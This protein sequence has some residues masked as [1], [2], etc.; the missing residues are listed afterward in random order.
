MRVQVKDKNANVVAIIGGGFSGTMVAYHLLRQSDKPLQITIFEPRTTLGLGLAY[1]TPCPDHLLNVPAAG[2]SAFVDQPLHFFHHAQTLD[3]RNT[4][5]TF[6]SRRQF[7]QYIN[8]LFEAAL[9]EQVGHSFEHRTQSVVDI[10]RRDGRYALRLADGVAYDTD[11]V[12]LATGNLS[13]RPFRWA[14]AFADDARY[15]HD[16]WQSGAIEAID[17]NSDVLLLGTGLTAVDKLIELHNQQHRGRIWATSRH[18]LLPFAH[19]ERWVGIKDERDWDDL[20]GPLGTLRGAVRQLRGRALANMVQDK[21]AWRPVFDGC[22]A[23]TQIWW[24]GLELLEQKRFMRHLRTYYDVHR[25]RM[26]P[27]IDHVVQEMRRDGRL[28][29]IA[30]RVMGAHDNGGKIAVQLQPRHGGD[31]I[32]LQL[33]CIINCTGPQGNVEAVEQPLFRNLI[34]GGRASQNAMGSSLLVQANGCVGPVDD[35]FY[36]IGPLLQ[37]QLLE[38]VAVPEL[39]VQATNVAQAILRRFD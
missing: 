3:D 25:H 29:I 18:G 15:L 26:A 16:P 20:D 10:E 27:R 24:Q 33:D 32:E 38:S 28:L 13:G 31:S 14:Q 8:G 11:V 5:E 36:A 22:R 23:N 37:S 30:G 17:I 35:G 2:M 1:S 9:R 12:V 34:A 4:P 7:G 21:E 19:V 6:V 39:R